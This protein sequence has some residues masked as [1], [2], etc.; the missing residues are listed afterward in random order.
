[1]KEQKDKDNGQKEKKRAQKDIEKKE[2]ASRSS[3]RS[4]SPVKMARSRS[5]KTFRAATKEPEPPLPVNGEVPLARKG[6]VLKKAKR[7]LSAFIPS[8]KSSEKVALTK[9]PSLSSLRSKISLEKLVPSTVE[10]E[11]EVIMTSDAS[12]PK[13]PPMPNFASVSAERTFQV[14]EST[15][16]K[17]DE[18]WTAFRSLDAEYQK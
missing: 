7:P 6:T 18:L 16:K 13:V 4:T 12:S 14:A 17:K 9:S 11:A 15:F 8:T 3:S 5:F 2:Q 10:K 1:M